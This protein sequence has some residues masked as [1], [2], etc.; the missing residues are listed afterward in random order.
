MRNAP[1]N[2]RSVIGCVFIVA[3]AIGVVGLEIVM[4]A[5]GGQGPSLW[6]L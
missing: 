2:R 5:D 1:A 6:E 4:M 3:R